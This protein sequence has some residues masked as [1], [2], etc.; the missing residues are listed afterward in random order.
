MNWKRIVLGLFLLAGM[1]GVLALG[2]SAYVV[3]STRARVLEA[4]APPPEDLDCILVLGC[5]VRPDGSPSHMLE[6]R[7]KRAIQLYQAGWSDVL[8]LSGDNRKEDY[9]E[10][11]VM[12]AY[13]MARGVPEEAIVLDHAGLCTYDSLYR[14]RA[15]FGA[16]RVVV[17]TQAFHIS[18]ALYI[19]RSLGVEAWGVTADLRP[20]Q[21]ELFNR[22]REILARDKDALWCLV[23]PEPKHLGEKVPL[24][25]AG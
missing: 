2:L 3:S 6:D 16:E 15:I 4:E 8:L 24:R 11:G 5:G 23:K 1:L 17:I 10:V 12:K 14:A 13:A 9:N 18:R 19:G 21:H 22:C 25:P 7:M 20:Y